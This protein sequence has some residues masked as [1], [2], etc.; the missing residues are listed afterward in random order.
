ML[1]IIKYM[2]LFYCMSR[3]NMCYKHPLHSFF[4]G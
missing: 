4:G 3:N 1:L 2:V